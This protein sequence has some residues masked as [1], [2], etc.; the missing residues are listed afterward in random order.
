[1]TFAPLL[2]LGVVCFAARES[3]NTTSPSVSRIALAA[4]FQARALTSPKRHSAFP[5][6]NHAVQQTPSV[7]APDPHSWNCE[8]PSYRSNAL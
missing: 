5:N 1:M 6:L 8:R 2:R 7:V 4:I 3:A